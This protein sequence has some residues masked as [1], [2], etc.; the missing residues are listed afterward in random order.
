[1]ANDPKS[2]V[3]RGYDAMAEGYL[4]RFGR[5]TVRERWLTELIARLP[6]TASVLDLGCGAGIPVARELVRHGHRVVAI[7]AS[8]RQI[9]LAQGNV[10][11]ANFIHLEMT[12]AAF[13][14]ASFDA[15]TAF[16]SITHLP[17]DEHAVLLRR[18]ARWLKPEGIFLGS[19]GADPCDDWRGDWLGAEM[20]FSHYGAR[21]NEQLVR[22]AGLAIERAEL[23]DQ[24]DDDAR[25]LWVIARRGSDTGA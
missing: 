22:D 17:R 24:D 19:L 13:A 3:A 5:S 10:P 7:D 16:Y 18:I 21:M 20:F 25:F 1:M 4:E 14:P 6:A 23:V 15:V 11:E 9:E 2:I 8:I 12:S